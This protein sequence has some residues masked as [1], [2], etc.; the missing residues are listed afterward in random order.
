ML[1]PATTL[2]EDGQESDIEATKYNPPPDSPGAAGMRFAY[3]TGSRPLDGFTIKRGIG[4]GGFGEVYFA[5]SDAGKEVAL[6]RIQRSMDVEIRGVS[7]CLNLKHPNLVALYDI[8]YDEEGR[9]W[10]VMEYIRGESLKEVIERNPNGLP[11]EELR[12]WFLDVAAGVG[13]LHDHGIVHRDL[14]PA[15]IFVDQGVVK[16]GDYGLS[17]FISCSRRSGQ[18]ESVGTFHY[19]APEIGKGVYGKEID[20]YALGII[21][22]ELLTGTVPFDGESSQE[23]I[24]KHLTAEPDLSDVPARYRPTI[25]KA[26]FKDPGRRY[27]TV[28]EMV[29]S[30][31]AAG[32]PQVRTEVPPVRVPRQ[33][34]QA[35]AAAAPQGNDTLYIL[36]DDENDSSGIEL[37]PLKE[38]TVSEATAPSPRSAVPPGAAVTA[39]TV[40]TGVRP[41]PVAHAVRSGWSRIRTWWHQAHFRLPIKILLLAGLALLLILNSEWLIP[42]GIVLGAIYLI[43]FGVRSVL[44]ALRGS[45]REPAAVNREARY[46]ASRTTSVRSTGTRRKWQETAR[47]SLRRRTISERFGELSGSLLMSTIVA[48]VMSLV[49]LMVGNVPLDDS[50]YT[51]TFF[52]WLAI[53][54]TAGAWGVLA[55]SKFWEGGEG[56]QFLRRFV[57]LVGGLLLGAAAFGAGEFLEVRWTDMMTAQ[58]APSGELLASMYQPNGVPRLPA[59]MIYFAVL[60]VLMRWWL[61][62]DPLRATRLSLWSTGVCV[63]LGWVVSLVWQFPQPWGL[64]LPATIAVAV[65]LSAPWVPPKQR[66][67][68][69]RQAAATA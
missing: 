4:V 51:W 67:E 6:K 45:N 54:T 5:V 18:T 33:H 61:Q 25:Q 44:L 17:K 11:E 38:V 3:A 43:Y 41:E 47:E 69:R 37:G 23:I 20:V 10:V 55:T 14:K 48:V 26:L 35:A 12:A 30:L 2:N 36:D 27:A 8:K 28:R 29:A 57:L 46:A 65:Q 58:P 1:N 42:L 24:M 60:S 68:F 9:G 31:E 49:M 64:M 50:V 66:A 53:T 63:L 32:Q 62:A 13:A 40:A 21:L 59:F 7:Q 19:M 52:S 22:F 39:A 15:N 56:E 34:T 16:I